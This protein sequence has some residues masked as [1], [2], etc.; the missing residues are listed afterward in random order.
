MAR[1]GT[2]RVTTAPAPIIASEPIVRPGRIVAFAPI[3]APRLTKVRVYDA[4]FCLLRGNG[5]LVNVAL[6]PTKTSSSRVT[7]SQSCTPHLTVTRSPTS[8]PPS[9][10]VWSQMLQSAPMRAPGST[11]AKAQMRVLGPIVPVSTRA[12]GCAKY[13]GELSRI[14]RAARAVLIQFLQVVIA[15]PFGKL[16]YSYFE[17]RRRAK[18]SGALQRGH[19]RVGV[20]HVARL[21]RPESFPRAPSQG[22]FK[23]MHKCH[24]R[25]GLAAA[26]VEQT[27]ALGSLPREADHRFDNVVDVRKIA[28]HA[29]V[30]ENVD[31]VS[32]RD[33][34]GEF[35]GRHVRP[36]PWSIDGEETEPRRRDMKQ[37]AIGVGHQ[38]IGLFRCGVE[39]HR[40]IDPI[41][42]GEGD[43]CIAAVDGARRR[44][45]Q[46]R[47]ARAAAAFED[48]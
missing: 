33:R 22:G 8:A 21:Q 5:S 1:A 13:C 18:F 24:Q 39:R 25:N 11:C 26:D 20:D 43:F 29:A 16:S 19:I 42:H 12:S 46:M 35:I 28:L 36:S 9:I 40:K 23:G 15:I 10:K 4:G 34:S 3:E 47:D 27:V 2:S 7:P 30:V 45:D 48:I 41:F 6:G 14:V 37:V 44:I 31:Y 38:L 17:R 32:S